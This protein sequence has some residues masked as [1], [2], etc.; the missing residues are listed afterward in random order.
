MYGL[1]VV[2]FFHSHLSLSHTHTCTHMHMHAHTHTHTHSQLDQ[3]MEVSLREMLVSSAGK[4]GEIEAVA[5]SGCS[6][7]H[8]CM[9][10]F[11]ACHSLIPTYPICVPFL[12]SLFSLS[13]FLPPSITPSLSSPP[14]QHRYQGLKFV[15]ELAAVK[16]EDVG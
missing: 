10:R 3:L 6:C 9:H 7:V 16:L 8:L 5:P 13:P 4:P 11:T 12:L 1:A 2:P 15:S 14:I